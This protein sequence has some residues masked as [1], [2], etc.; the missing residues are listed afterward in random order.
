[1][2]STDQRLAEIQSRADAATEPTDEGGWLV[3]PG[4]RWEVYSGKLSKTS[5]D[6]ATT[7][8]KEADARFIAAART[9]VP[10]LVAALRAVLELCGWS[11]EISR[12][13]WEGKGDPKCPWP[14][15]AQTS[16]NDILTAIAAALEP[17]PEQ[18]TS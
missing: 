14:D 1:M 17:A 2:S 16:V 8:F 5:S 11:E 7:I 6:V 3:Y 9:D 12:R 13:V 10:R 15:N 4:A 18:V